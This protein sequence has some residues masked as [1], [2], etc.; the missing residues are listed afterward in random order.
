MPSIPIPVPEHG[1]VLQNIRD[2]LARLMEEQRRLADLVQSRP[3]ADNG[4][5]L[6][7]LRGLEN[8]LQAFG[9]QPPPP[10]SVV[11]PMP[12]PEPAQPP[13]MTQPPPLPEDLRRSPSTRSG[14]TEETSSDSLE[15]MLRA[16]RTNGGI[17]QPQPRHYDRANLA[18]L[19]RLIAEPLDQTGFERPQPYTDGQPLLPRVRPRD[20]V[21][22]LLRR[23]H[24][25]PPIE[26]PPFDLPEIGPRRA[27][28]P[29][30]PRA[31]RRRARPRQPVIPPS[32]RPIFQ[33]PVD[34]DDRPAPQPSAT[35]VGPSQERRPRPGPP[36]RP[37]AFVSAIVS[38]K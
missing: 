34:R 2:D 15:E 17:V 6:D 14:V 27:P 21:E 11:I 1:D 37:I 9:G 7:R 32:E 19:D 18:D 12:V 22:T 23:P 10:P 8:L 24:S 13:V 25:E 30:T 29:G 3:D 16:L 33:R 4:P 20:S 31:P 28:P 5:V 35:P 26:F 36:V 38:L